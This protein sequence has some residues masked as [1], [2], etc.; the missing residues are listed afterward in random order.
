VVE[1]RIKLW[2][3]DR[4]RIRIQLETNN[5]IFKLGSPPTQLIQMTDACI[6][7]SGGETLAATTSAR[8]VFTLPPIGCTLHG[9]IYPGIPDIDAAPAPLLQ[10]NWTIRFLS[11]SHWELSNH[12]RIFPV[13]KKVQPPIPPRFLLGYHHVATTAPVRPPHLPVHYHH[14]NCPY[15][16]VVKSVQITPLKVRPH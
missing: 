10:L 2:Y 7:H 9:P 15:T 1:L 14:N 16:F 6:A 8:S 12:S 3:P 5:H 13:A 11:L 4:S